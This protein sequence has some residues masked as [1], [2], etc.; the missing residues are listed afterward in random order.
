MT[1][2]TIPVSVPVKRAPR[3]TRIL[4][5][6]AMAMLRAGVPLATNVLVTVPGRVSG[7][8]RT[9]PLAVIEVDGR[10]WLW[11]PWG[12]V[13]W[14]RNLRAAGRATITVRRQ[15]EE[16]TATELDPAE[17]IVF[18]RDVLAPFAR[19]LRGGMAFVRLIDG[20]DLNHPVEEAEGRPVFELHPVD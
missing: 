7:K 17:R 6:F 2:Q 20:V 4:N 12:D 15:S 10:R 1:D 14:V 19:N 8:P 18:F 9:T 13:Q 16:V 5:P 11:S 3:I